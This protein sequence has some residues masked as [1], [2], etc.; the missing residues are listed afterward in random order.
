MYLNPDLPSACAEL[1]EMQDAHM[2]LHEM[3]QNATRKMVLKPGY[4]P[5]GNI[6]SLL[7]LRDIG[8]IE[9][10]EDWDDLKQEEFINYKILKVCN[11]KS[12]GS[13]FLNS[14]FLRTARVRSRG[15]ESFERPSKSNPSP[16]SND[17]DEVGVKSRTVQKLTRT[18]LAKEYFPKLLIEHQI[19]IWGHNANA[20]VGQ[21]GNLLKDPT[22]SLEDIQWLMEFSLDSF[23]QYYRDTNFPA[24]KVFISKS[25]EFRNYLENKKANERRRQ[26]REAAARQ[27]KKESSLDKMLREQRERKAA[28]EEEADDDE[29]WQRSILGMGR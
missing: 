14:G 6:A 16:V 5:S 23:P 19:P 26:E 4:R 11:C 29:D 8:A 28:E 12:P 9:G 25:R 1:A 21:L 18:Y 17:K 3:T 13:D 22:V 27:P 15:N 2:L 10:F 7:A 20:L 24:W